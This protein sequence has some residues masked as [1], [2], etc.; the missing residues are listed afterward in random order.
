MTLTNVQHIIYELQAAEPLDKEQL[1]AA[2]GH[3]KILITLE[4]LDIEVSKLIEVGWIE[5]YDLMDNKDTIAYTLSHRWYNLT[6]S[7]K[8]KILTD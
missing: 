6:E 4:D 3:Q 2:L 7:E 5:F 8:E 1:Q